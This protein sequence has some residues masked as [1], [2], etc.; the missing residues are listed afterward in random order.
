MYKA[1]FMKF[2]TYR[3]N[4]GND[5]EYRRQVQPQNSMEHSVP[6]SDNIASIEKQEWYVSQTTKYGVGL[7]PYLRVCTL[8]V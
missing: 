1:K 4:A 5:L 3:F 7:L 8:H 6:V 2:N